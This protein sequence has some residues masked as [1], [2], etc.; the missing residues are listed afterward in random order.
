MKTLSENIT[1]VVSLLCLLLF[2][3]CANTER[4]KTFTSI[5]HSVD[6][7]SY[8]DL[9]VGT[10]PTLVWIDVNEAGGNETEKGTPFIYERNWS[11]NTYCDLLNKYNCTIHSEYKLEESGNRHL[12]GLQRSVSRKAVGTAD[13]DDAS[14]LSSMADV[15]IQTPEPIYISS[16]MALE[17]AT[18]PYCYSQNLEVTWNADP[19]NQYGIIALAYW[20][21]VVIG[22]PSGGTPVYHAALVP[23]D[24]D[25]VLYNELFDGMP[26]NAY[27]SLY[28]IRANIV[29]VKQ[30]G[31]TANIEDIDWEQIVQENPELVCQTTNIAI[32]SAAKLS[33]VLRTEL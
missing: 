15:E 12:V 22:S 16:P 4:E 26:N 32:G 7:L 8:M 18:L 21:G 19:N 3:A 29:Q 31:S 1:L 30:D 24:G 9:L 14:S 28:L 27:V 25:C 23:D 10:N 5:A 11:D 2:S 17:C 33:F 20:T 13:D 6:T